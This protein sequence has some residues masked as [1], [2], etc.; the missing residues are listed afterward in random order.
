MP[1]PTGAGRAT[2]S[3]F[4]PD[5]LRSQ[6]WARSTRS[7][8]PSGARRTK[9]RSP[10]ARSRLRGLAG[11][12]CSREGRGLRWAGLRRRC[13]RLAGSFERE[14]LQAGLLTFVGGGGVRPGAGHRL[15]FLDHRKRP[16]ASGVLCPL[17]TSSLAPGSSQQKE[18]LTSAQE[19]GFWVS[20]RGDVL[21]PGRKHHLSSLSGDYVI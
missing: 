15:L 19:L 5:P 21:S 20:G 10:R 13:L 18:G 4:S 8:R 16:W 12:P 2:G 7:T 1:L 6:P 3:R 14:G 17:W 9:V 11:G